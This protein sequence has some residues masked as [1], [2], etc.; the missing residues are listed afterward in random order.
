MIGIYIMTELGYNYLDTT[1]TG[2]S[3]PA[4]S[5]NALFPMISSD[6]GVCRTLGDDGESE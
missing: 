3:S 6:Q 2:T 1:F 5:G 4:L